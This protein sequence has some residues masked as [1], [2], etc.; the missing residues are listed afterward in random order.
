MPQYKKKELRMTDPDQ[1]L[2]QVYAH[3]IAVRK[4]LVCELRERDV[5]VCLMQN[6]EQQYVLRKLPA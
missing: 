5:F 4:Y 6:E 3:K 1:K 2:L